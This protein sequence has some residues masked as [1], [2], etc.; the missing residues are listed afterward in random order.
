[1]MVSDA[2]GCSATAE[3]EIIQHPE[4]KGK[5]IAVPASAP[6]KCKLYFQP[7][8]LLA[9]YSYLWSTGEQTDT[10]ETNELNIHLTIMDTNQ[11][12]TTITFICNPVAN[13]DESVEPLQVSPNPNKGSFKIYSP[14]SIDKLTIFSVNGIRIYALN[15]NVQT[16]PIHQI[17]INN[18]APGIYLGRAV[19]DNKNISFRIV[20]E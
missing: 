1:M 14:N 6:T 17:N 13:E 20:V 9:N 10:I 19:I 7:D 5:I 3:K 11:C 2:N 16:E 15:T 8:D 18:L 4:I 12:K